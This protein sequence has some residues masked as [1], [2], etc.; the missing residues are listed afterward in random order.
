MK[1]VQLGPL[2]A[3]ITPDLSK[4]EVKKTVVLLHGYGAP[5]TDLVGLERAIDA[6]EGTRFVFFQAPNT[7]DGTSGPNAGRAWWHIDMMELQIAR[8]TGQNEALA[9]S[10]PAGISEA[11]AF[12]DEALL[13]LQT[14]FGLDWSALVIGGFSQ[15]AMLSC[16]WALRSPHPI[17]ALLQLSGTMISE[18]EW[19]ELMLKRAP[20]RVFQSHSPDD[21]VLPF[22]LAERLRD[23]MQEAKLTTTFVEFRGGHGIASS[24]TDALSA[25]L[26][27]QDS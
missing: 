17:E 15:G 5:G 2:S 12:L 26:S 22:V 16:D 25:F 23:A 18:T 13:A 7:I 19:R 1:A 20:L 6:P 11:C 3:I 10:T 27:R 24:V 14:E 8:M 21:Q 4:D 9:E